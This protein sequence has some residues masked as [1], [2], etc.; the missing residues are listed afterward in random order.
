MYILMAIRKFILHFLAIL[1]FNVIFLGHYIPSPY[2]CILLRHATYGM[3][4][5][6]NI[7]VIIKSL[8]ISNNISQRITTI[9]VTTTA[10]P[11]ARNNYAVA[12]R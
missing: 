11:S 6:C 9:N 4:N 12:D 2:R 7:V 3:V 1:D 10:A 5:D 8:L